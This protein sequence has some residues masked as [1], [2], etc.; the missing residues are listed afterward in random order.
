MTGLGRDSWMNAK[1]RFLALV[2]L[3]FVSLL[4]RAQDFPAKDMPRMKGARLLVGYPPQ[5]LLVTTGAD[6]LR[7]KPDFL[8]ETAAANERTI[9]PSISKDGNTVAAAQWRGGFPGRIASIA[10]YSIKDKKWTIY[11]TG[12][13]EGAVAVSPD[14]SKLAFVSEVKSTEK[15]FVHPINFIDL[16][17]GEQTAGPE[18]ALSPVKLGVHTDRSFQMFLTWAPDSKRIAYGDNLKIWVWDSATQQSNTIAEGGA[19]AWSPDGKW[20]AYLDS[21][22]DPAHSNCAI[23]RPDGA[24]KKILVS[25]GYGGFLSSPRRFV[26]VPVWSPDSKFVL[27]NQRADGEKE[28]VDIDLLEVITG[29]LKRIMRNKVPV[30]GWAKV[31]SDPD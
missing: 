7:L 13:F 25:P 14:G 23:V 2:G 20:I 1:S 6:T 9:Y 11:N 18:V 17:T 27:L 31:S 4:A 26:E 10:T 28:T 16:K 21:A 5:T 3:C 19:P 24:G 22:S 15:G 8:T 29:K 12:K 30:Y